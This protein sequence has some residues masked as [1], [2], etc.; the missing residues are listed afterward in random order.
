MLSLDD[1]VTWVDPAKVEGAYIRTERIMTRTFP[2]ARYG[3][4]EYHVHAFMVSGREV[5]GVSLG[6]APGGLA[7]ASRI[8]V[9]L[10]QA[11][12]A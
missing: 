2:A 10:C 7:R 11:V 6:E 1:G 3:P 5:H 12:E 9:A 8:L 4:D